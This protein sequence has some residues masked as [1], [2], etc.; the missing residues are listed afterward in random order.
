MKIKIKVLFSLILGIVILVALSSST[1][2]S[3]KLNDARPIDPHAGHDHASHAKEAVAVDPHAGHDHASHAKEAAAVDPH[4]E[5]DHASHANPG[6]MAVAELLAQNCECGIKAIDCD[7]CRYEIGAVKIS[8]QI[9]AIVK[10]KAL[11]LVRNR[12]EISF[13]GELEYDTQ[14]IR[15]V[16]SLVPGVISTLNVRKG[17]FVEQG[18]VIAQIESRELSHT[19]LVLQKQISELGLAQ[20]KLAREEMLNQKKIGSLQSVQE[21][22]SASELAQIEVKCT[23]ENLALYG[24]TAKE[25]AAIAAGRAEA[26][27]K[28]KLSLASPIQGRIVKLNGNVGS[29]VNDQQAIAEI[30]DI[31]Q[32]RAVGQI[33]EADLATVIAELKKKSINGFISTQAFP[34]LFFPVKAVSADTS[35]KP[36]TRTLEIQLTVKNPDELLRPGMF[37]EGTLEIGDPEN[38]PTLPAAAVLEDDGK[39]FVFVKHDNSTFLRRDITIEAHRGDSVII[40]GGIS[41]GDEVVVEGSF[42]LKSDI[43]RGKMGAGCAH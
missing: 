31:R 43:L 10:T 17:D 20:K 9:E 13:R 37:I 38:K 11:A 28:G 5:H 27:Q 12:K 2:F 18:Q 25:I 3:Q 7:E 33:R 40:S 34:G 19:A 8:P 35:L 6:S 30:V 21:A 29:A 39:Y 24:L 1:L 4:A 26:V 23:K 16:I 42:L 14:L 32:L 41:D 15:T 36:T 22:Q